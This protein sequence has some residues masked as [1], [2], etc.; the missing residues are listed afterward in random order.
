MGI[1]FQVA[2]EA[3]MAADDED[4][5]EVPIAGQVFYARRPTTAQAMLLNQSLNGTGA[6]RLSATFRLVE[7]LMGEKAQALVEDLIWARRI[8]LGDLIGGSD[9]NP[10]G[11]LIDQIFAEFTGRPTAPSTDS[12]G[13][14]SAGGRRS[15]GR[16]PGKGS[17]RSP[18]PSIDS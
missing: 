11:G 4:V 10:D 17:T 3:A 7:G 14:Q 9:Q 1:N 8:D 16:S 2:A 12:S 13:S 6:A 15:T 5:V 18:S